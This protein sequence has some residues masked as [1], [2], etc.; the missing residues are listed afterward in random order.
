ML[1]SFTCLLAKARRHLL[2]GSEG[3]PV[4][5]SLPSALPLKKSSTPSPSST[6]IPDLTLLAHSPSFKNRSSLDIH[7]LLLNHLSQ[8]RSA[9]QEDG[10]RASVDPRP[11]TQAFFLEEP[12]IFLRCRVPS[13]QVSSCLACP[14]CRQDKEGAGRSTTV[15]GKP[16]SA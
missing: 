13:A 11:L 8:T 4:Q 15:P 7:S 14:R 5:A 16:E 3:K 6:S 10:T 1:I 2:S 9:A 12:A